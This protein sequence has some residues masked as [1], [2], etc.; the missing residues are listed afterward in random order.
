MELEPTE[1]QTEI[2]RGRGTSFLSDDGLGRARG[3]SRT[4]V[5]VGRGQGIIEGSGTG[6]VGRSRARARTRAPRRSRSRNR[7]SSYSRSIPITNDDSNSAPQ[8]LE[9]EERERL[10]SEP[11]IFDLN[12]LCTCYYVYCQV[13]LL[14]HQIRCRN[15]CISKCIEIDV[16]ENIVSEKSAAAEQLGIPFQ[17]K[18]SWPSYMFGM[19]STFI[20]L[21]DAEQ[22]VKD[23]V[24]GKCNICQINVR[25]SLVATSNFKRHL[26]TYHLQEFVQFEDNL[27]K[28]RRLTPKINFALATNLQNQLDSCLVDLIVIDN[29]PLN[30]IRRPGFR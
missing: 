13:S 11:G 21:K 25:G 19:F 22:A 24:V 5:G 17:G 14:S 9:D 4:I 15:R 12:R 8:S 2:A 16:N 6:S 3:R 20:L 23:V 18:E 26:D 30:I 10:E 7:S 27:D 29:L 1:R 28:G